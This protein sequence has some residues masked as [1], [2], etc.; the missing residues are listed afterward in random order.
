M[1]ILKTKKFGSETE[2]VEFVASQAIKKEDIVTITQYGGYY[3]I[4]YYG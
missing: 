3:T 2:L 4:F 1:N